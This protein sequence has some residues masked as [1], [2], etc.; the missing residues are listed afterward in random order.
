[1][2]GVF[3]NYRKVDSALG[4]VLLDQK[5]TA[6]F[7]ADAVFRD[8][9][10][11]ELATEFAPVLWKALRR[12]D[13]VLVVIGPHWL[14]ESKGG[15]RLI[16]HADDFVRTEIAEALR[17]GID[18]LPVLVGGTALPAAKDLPKN[19]RGLSKRQY[20]SVRDRDPEPD[21]DRL[22]ERLATRPDLAALPAPAQVSTRDEQETERPATSGISINRLTVGRD[23][24]LGN[25]TNHYRGDR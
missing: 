9:R 21:L 19:I 1:M 7:G 25:Q 11:I 23:A 4:A 24:I 5:L 10:S 17:L 15:K 18:V 2:G 13:V 6:R 12:C 3:I 16:D 22:V 20:H 14:S 8:N